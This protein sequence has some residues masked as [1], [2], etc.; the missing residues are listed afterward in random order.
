ME[1]FKIRFFQGILVGL[2]FGF[3]RK[4]K[5]WKGSK[6]GYTK[7]SQ[8]EVWNF[9]LW[10]NT[11]WIQIC[12]L[13]NSVIFFKTLGLWAELMKYISSRRCR[14]RDCSS[15]C[16]PHNS[17]FSQVWNLSFWSNA[18]LLWVTHA[19]FEFMIISN[20]EFTWY[21]TRPKRMTLPLNGHK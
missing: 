16:P 13:C 2:K 21:L 6:F 20:A 19:Y 5:V 17:F 7:F 1:Y 12:S 18:E 9:W 11:I 4:C 10:H 3:G 8:F 15:V 14:L